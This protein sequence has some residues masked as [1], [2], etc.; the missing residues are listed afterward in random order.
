MDREILKVVSAYRPSVF[1]EPRKAKRSRTPIDELVRRYEDG[2][3]LWT[4]EPLTGI[5]KIHSER[6]RAGKKEQPGAI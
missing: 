3:N 4:G 5:E 2:Q 1:G 6:L